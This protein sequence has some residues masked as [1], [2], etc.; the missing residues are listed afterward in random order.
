MNKTKTINIATIFATIVMLIASMVVLSACGDNN[1]QL[2]TIE[3]GS[4]NELVTA[5]EGDADIIKLSADIVAEGTVKVGR[6]FVLDMNGK[7]ISNTVDIWNDKTND[8]SLVSVRENGNLTIKGDGKF[9][10]KAYDC[11]AVDVMDGGK[12]TVEN[13][14]FVGNISA[15]YIYEGHAD[16]KGGKYSIQQL[17]DNGVESEFGQMVNL[18]NENADA[19][20]ASVAITGGVFKGFNP[21][22][23][24]HNA[25]DTLVPDGYEAKLVEGSKSDY[26][27]VKSAK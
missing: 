2:K 19:N 23:K 7:Q 25:H 8:W 15:V 10:T 21:T 27:I 13:G 26:E 9:L 5:V 22:D 11:Y 17:N 4:Y 6:K 24:T 16:I 1:K 20:K 3:V 14:V 18:Y 12:L